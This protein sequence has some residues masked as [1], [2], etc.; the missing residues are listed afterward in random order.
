[1]TQ[2]T[3]SINPSLF[4][5]GKK[6]K[7]EKK[8]K[9]KKPISII[10]PNSLKNK[11]IQKVKQHQQNKEKQK[12]KKKK[13]TNFGNNFQE[14]LRYLSNLIEENQEKNV[15]NFNVSN[16][17]NKL[18]SFQNEN[19][20]RENVNVELPSDLKKPEVVYT[21]ELKTEINTIPKPYGC[22]KNGN[23]PTYRQWL[24]TRK[25]N[26]NKTT[27]LIGE[28]PKN[29]ILNTREEKLNKVKSMFLKKK[30]EDTSIKQPNTSTIQNN[31]SI[32]KI[33]DNNLDNNL[34]NN[35]DNVDNNTNNII[36]NVNEK[37]KQKYAIKTNITRK[38][39]C[40][41]NNKTRKVGVIIKNGET[42]AKI[43]REKRNLTRRNIHDVKNFLY[44]N[45][46]LKVGSSAPKKILIDMY[47]ACILTGK[48]SN[49]NDRIHI[50]NY[51]N[52]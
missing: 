39:T 50:H 41:K 1:M 4:T 48:I 6:T 9:E 22:L 36:L 27:S 47:E 2:K 38:Y 24:Y 23:K 5:V 12:T 52:P 49:K 17:L 8:I 44:K 3:I 29:E 14:S 34:D 25:N 40:G 26:Q 35:F 31:N 16:N 51:L 15:N 19:Y 13:E 43:I 32:E 20:L 11:F 30:E 33:I 45:G 28:L 18:E 10:T 37:P 42:K 46:F 7:K 21:N